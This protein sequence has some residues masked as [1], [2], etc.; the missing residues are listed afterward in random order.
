MEKKIP[1]WVEDKGKI[2]HDEEIVFIGEMGVDSV[3]DG[4]LPNGETYEWS[5]KNRRRLKKSR[6]VARLLPNKTG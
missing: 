3:V 5:K 2:R 1:K 4:K 6:I